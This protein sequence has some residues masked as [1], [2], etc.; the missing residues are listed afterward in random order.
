MTTIFAVAA[1][2]ADQ[3]ASPPPS[4]SNEDRRY[5]RQLGLRVRVL[6][7]ARELT[8]DQLADRAG[9]DRT[10][11][12]RLERGQHNLTV[13]TL[14]RLTQALDVPTKEVLP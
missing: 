1:D 8:Q 12:S 13:L 10:Y 5:L 11:V 4:R 2:H 3:Q 14:L 6:R 7:T 9:L